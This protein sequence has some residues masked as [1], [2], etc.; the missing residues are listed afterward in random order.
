MLEARR[1][2][3]EAGQGEDQENRRRHDGQHGADDPQQHH[4]GAG[5]GPGPAA[6]AHAV[7]FAQW[8]LGVRLPHQARAPT[9]RPWLRGGEAV[10]WAF[11]MRISW[12]VWRVAVMFFLCCVLLYYG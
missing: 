7:R 6:Q 4:Q 12:R 2:A 3:A 1:G 9:V 5:G 10:G 11:K 8:R